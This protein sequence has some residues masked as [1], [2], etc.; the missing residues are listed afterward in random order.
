MNSE[1]SS[2]NGEA[3]NE[4]DEQEKGVPLEQGSEDGDGSVEESSAAQQLPPGEPPS[5]DDGLGTLGW[6]VSQSVDFYVLRTQLMFQFGY[7]SQVFI[8][9]VVE[10]VTPIRRMRRRG[11]CS[12][13]GF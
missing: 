2:E 4:D 11:S 13:G 8:I 1:P 3:S 9:V 10:V 6:N 5:E 12:L 7:Y